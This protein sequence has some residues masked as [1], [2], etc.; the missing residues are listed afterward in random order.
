MLCNMLSSNRFYTAGQQYRFQIQLNFDQPQREHFDRL[1]TAS[2][3]IA[4]LRSG[5]LL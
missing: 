2:E 1:V 3:L 4:W 5:R